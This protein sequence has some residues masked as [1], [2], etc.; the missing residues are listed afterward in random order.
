MNRRLWAIAALIATAVACTR[1][2]SETPLAWRLDRAGKIPSG[3]ATYTLFLNTSAAYP[4]ADAPKK[5]AVLKRQFEEFGHSIGDKNLAVWANE[6]DS[7]K[8]SVSRGK[9]YAD[10]F[11]RWSGQSVSYNDGPYVIVCDRHP[12]E[13]QTAAAEPGASPSVIIISFRNVASDRIIEVLNYLEERIRRE[14]LKTAQPQVYALWI[15]MKSWW[16]GAD[17][18]FMKSVTLA[19]LQKLPG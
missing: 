16:D 11:A 12:D 9:Y 17:R 3:F 13:L 5:L 7:D 2:M 18:E 15:K 14:E 1:H 6:P 8:L 4:D 10:V 19:L